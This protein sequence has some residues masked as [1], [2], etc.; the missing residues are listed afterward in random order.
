MKTIKLL[1]TTYEVKI[2]E[3]GFDKEQLETRFTEYFLD[4]DY[5][6]GDWSYGKLRLK[7]FCKKT[8]KLYNEIND[9]TKVEEYLKK[10]C[11]YG[12]KHFILEKMD[13]K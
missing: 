9:Y 11:A 8:N 1:D 13:Q 7:G 4:Y 12:C 5:V 10:D 2:D 6:L 3:N